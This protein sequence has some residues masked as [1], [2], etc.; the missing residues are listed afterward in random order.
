VCSQTT[1]DYITVC[2]KQIPITGKAPMEWPQFS[3]PRAMYSERKGN[4]RTC[5]HLVE[6]VAFCSIKIIKK[7][8]K[9]M[10]YGNKIASDI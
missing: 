10:V 5:F 2:Q 6:N 7:S 1:L 3:G 4:V 8:L 9:M